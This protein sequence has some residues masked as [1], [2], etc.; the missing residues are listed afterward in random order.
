[1]DLHGRRVLVTAALPMLAELPRRITELL[2]TGVDHH[3]T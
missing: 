3:T 2:L 1:M